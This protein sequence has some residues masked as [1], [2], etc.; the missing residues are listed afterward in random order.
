MLRIL[1]IILFIPLKIAFADNP[2]TTNV[3]PSKEEMLRV[4]DNDIILG[5]PEAKNVIIEYSSLSCPHCAD[6]YKNLFPKIKSSLINNC[7]VK[8]VYRDF[9]T[10]RSALKATALIRCITMDS[11]NKVNQDEFFRLMQT[12]FN[13]QSSW[14][15]SGDYENS[16][17]KILSIV[18][19]PQEKISLCMKN[20][21]IPTNIVS[22]S[23][24]AMKALSMS[25]SPCLFINNVE[26]HSVSYE[27]I[28][29]MLK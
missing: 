7:K 3:V 12:L 15:F 10:T 21:E 26:L 13:S 18:G 11:T 9:P 19:I 5:C 20:N 27:N 2:L 23:F 24:I 4:K 28:V 17:S 25:H 29:K 8:Y 14:A 22:N 16:L 6:Y 1:F